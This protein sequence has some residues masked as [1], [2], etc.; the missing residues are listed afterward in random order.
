VSAEGAPPSTRA[1]ALRGGQEDSCSNLPLRQADLE[2]ASVLDAA[3]PAKMKTA[4]HLRE[5]LF[6]FI[7][8]INI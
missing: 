3:S 1:A 5:S 6:S 7:N 2:I 8:T 4:S